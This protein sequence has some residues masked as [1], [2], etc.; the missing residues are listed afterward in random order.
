MKGKDN[1]ILKQNVGVDLDKEK[2]EAAFTVISA[3]MDTSVVATR[4]FENREQGLANFIDWLRKHSW[5]NMPVHVTMEATGVYYE[6]LAYRLVEQQFPVHVMLP[7]KAKKFAQSLDMKSKTDKLDA[8]ALGKMGV[9]R[10]LREW[11]P[12]SENLRGL[13]FLTRERESLINEKTR[14]SNALH[15]LNH[16]YG[17][18]EKSIARYESQIDFLEARIKEVEKDIHSLIQEDEVLGPKVQRIVTTPGLNISTVAV[19]IAETNG[20]AAINNIKQLVSYAGYDPRIQESG[21]WKGHSKISKQGNSHIR[22]ALYFPALSFKQHSNW[23]GKFYERLKA[24][25][26]KGMV[27]AVA[28]Q[29]KLLIVAYVLWKNNDVF[30]PQYAENLTP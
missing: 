11:Q 29:R 17:A 20:F 28:L 8:K 23:H 27:A 12:A 21:Q 1:Q 10:K 3:H 5:E 6:L 22:R 30:R 15:A 9:E 2:F 16:S 14:A 18:P 13:R 26:E 25:K 19:L 24:R 7:N 4:K